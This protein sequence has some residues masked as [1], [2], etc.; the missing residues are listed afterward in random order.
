MNDNVE[1][2]RDLTD[3]PARYVKGRRNL[4][5]RSCYRWWKKRDK[6]EKA[7]WWLGGAQTHDSGEWGVLNK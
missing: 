5:R 1:C 2:M 3:F 6:N 4:T 7:W